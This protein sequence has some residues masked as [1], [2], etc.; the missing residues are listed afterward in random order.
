MGQELHDD[1]CQ[2]LVGTTLAAKVLAQRLAQKG[3]EFAREA[4]TIIGL[5]EEGT[6]KTRQLARGR[7]HSSTAP[8]ELTDKLGELAEEGSRSGVSCRFRQSGYVVVAD[9]DSAEGKDLGEVSNSLSWRSMC[10]PARRS[11][12]LA[13][14]RMD[15]GARRGNDTADR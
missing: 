14:G 11:P 9:A 15:H 7:L 5:L 3:N 2:R 8:D 1:I 10:A 12:V 4:Q 13:A 6:S